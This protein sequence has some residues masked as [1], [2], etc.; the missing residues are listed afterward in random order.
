MIHF[1]TTRHGLVV[2]KDKAQ[3]GYVYGDPVGFETG[4]G[5]I[6]VHVHL[7]SEDLQKIAEAIVSFKKEG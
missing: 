3:I 7:T 1:E 5:Y 6:G 4:P 2:Y